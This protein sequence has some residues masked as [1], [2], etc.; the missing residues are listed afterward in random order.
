MQRTSELDE[1]RG[2]RGKG[3]GGGGEGGRQ[4]CSVIPNRSDPNISHALQVTP[5]S[6]KYESDQWQ[7]DLSKEAAAAGCPSVCYVAASLDGPWEEGHHGGIYLSS[8]QLALAAVPH[9]LH[10]PWAAVAASPSIFLR[11][12]HTACTHTAISAISGD[13]CLPGS[14][15]VTCSRQPFNACM[16]PSRLGH[17]LAWTVVH[18]AHWLHKLVS[19]P[20]RNRNEY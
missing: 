17:R 8:Q 5:T 6:V 11:L 12:H 13:A 20:V 4:I 1:E 15:R 7:A 18:S 14:S 9:Q 2:G 3:G 10:H 16:V 19:L